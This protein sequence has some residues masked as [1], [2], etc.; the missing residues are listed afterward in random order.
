MEIRKNELY[1]TDDLMRLLKC[2]RR[3][4]YRYIEEQGLPARRI[5]Q[6]RI[7]VLGSDLLDWLRTK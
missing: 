6:Q 1:T 2:A 4:V 3:T 7:F 5:T